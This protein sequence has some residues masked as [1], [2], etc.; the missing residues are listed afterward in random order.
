MKEIKLTI[1]RKEIPLKPEQIQALG[2]DL[3]DGSVC[4]KVEAGEVY[5]YVNFSGEVRQMCQYY[6]YTDEYLFNC[7]NYYNDEAYAKQVGLHQKLNNLLRRYSEQHGGDAK[8]DGKCPH[9]TIWFDIGLNK[10]NVTYYYEVKICGLVYFKSE[11]IARHA[12]EEVVLP[13]VNEHPDFVW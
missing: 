2:I 8:W 10:F 5:F 1:D 6:D 13:F 4:D 11:L 7:G 9:Y 12:I 3:N